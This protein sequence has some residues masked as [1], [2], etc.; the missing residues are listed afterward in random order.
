VVHNTSRSQWPAPVDE[1][2]DQTID[3]SS[4]GAHERVAG[5]PPVDPAQ[6]GIGPLRPLTLAERIDGALIGLERFRERPVIVAA[7]LLA[8]AGVAI[9]L[10]ALRST[11]E[12]RAV[13][14]LIPN[15]VL[16]PTTAAVRPAADVVVHVSGAVA[17]PGVYSI[18]ATARVIDAVEK[19]GGAMVDADLDQLNLAAVVVDG[20]Q[21]RVPLV[22][23]VLPAAPASGVAGVPVD[24]NRADVAALQ[25]LRG[26][27]P[28]TAEAIVAFREQNGA[29]RSVDDLLDVPGI[30]PAK[31]A[32]IVD[33]IVVR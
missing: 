11:D 10:P 20:Q 15:V 26:I 27:G 7:L 28:A 18:P 24:L 32:V 29:F 5:D 4:S 1:D 25:S 16:T 33:A 2:V 6:L 22:G 8:I 13:E 23:E 14:A 19:A 31:L 12:P 21:I 9:G 3:S 17:S 30:G